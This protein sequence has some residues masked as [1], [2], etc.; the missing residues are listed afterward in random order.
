MISEV[1][2]ASTFGVNAF[3]VRVETH[4][5]KTVPTR[6]I[7][8]GLPDS[9]VKEAGERVIAA[10]RNTGFHFPIQKVT[11]NLSPADVRKEGS[12]FDLPIALGVLCETG[13]IKYDMFNEYMFVGELSL[14]G[15]IR[16]IRGIL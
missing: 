8:V 9:S 7:I 6:F 13:Q 11:I 4:L 15:K 12:G 2:G 5:L 1:L 16:P 3:L 14:D 10:I